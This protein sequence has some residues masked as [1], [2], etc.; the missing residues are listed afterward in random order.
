M[1]GDKPVTILLASYN[2]AAFIS[3]QIESILNQTYK[4]W[5]LIIRD[6][7][8]EDATV[9]IIKNFRQ[10]F[11]AKIYLIIDDLGNLG[12]VKNFDVLLQ[13]SLNAEYIMFCDQDDV[14]LPQKI[15]ITLNEMVRIEQQYVLKKPILVH[16]NFVYVDEVLKPITSKK[17]YTAL[18]AKNLDFNH[19]L[20]QNPVYG[21]T[22][23]INKPLLNLVGNI[24]AAAENH[25]YWIAL[26]ASAFGKIS[27]L[28]K[29]TILYR[30]H[31]ANI[32]GNHDNNSFKKRFKRIF[33]K[34]KNFRDAQSKIDMS[35]AF[36]DKY[37]NQLNTFQ[38][39]IITDFIVL[40]SSKK[41]S[42]IIKNLNNGV[43]RQTLSQT[44]LFYITL[45]LHK[46]KKTL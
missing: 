16:T 5:Q 37:F 36:K 11:P 19:L 3:E 2:G 17:N 24:P 44:F 34:G 26:T 14:W 25:D 43:R 42:S 32:S 45:V 28:K 46:T 1:T 27:Y 35:I 20:A 41:I 13:N 22:M 30:Q 33:F 29:Q 6:D 23:M 18:K 8:S 9:T 39:K 15:E 21:C 38:K 40:A 4:N 10:K 31:A 7:L 12:S